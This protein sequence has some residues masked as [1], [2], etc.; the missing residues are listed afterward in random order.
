MCGRCAASNQVITMAETKII[1][2][3]DLAD[4]AAAF[5]DAW[6]RA[7]GGESVSETVLA[8]ESWEALAGIMTGER[9]RLLRHV[10]AHPEPS[11]SALARSLGRQYRRVHADVTVLEQAGLIDRSTGAVRVSVDRITAE[12]QL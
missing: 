8:F 9:Y 4:D 12:I 1:V 5:L 11:V 10:H 2:G 3:G 7:E 6:H